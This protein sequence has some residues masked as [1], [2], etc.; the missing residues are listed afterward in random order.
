[1]V[2]PQRIH[3]TVVFTIMQANSAECSLSPDDFVKHMKLHLLSQPCLPVRCFYYFKTIIIA[4]NKWD[5]RHSERP[6][7]LLKIVSVWVAALQ[8]ASE[9]SHMQLL[10]TFCVWYLSCN[11]NLK[12]EHAS[13]CIC[14]WF[15]FES[16]LSFN[17]FHTDSNNQNLWVQHW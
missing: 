5:N 12:G 14:F 15:L 10:N 11:A 1:M 13:E 9:L 6:G 2:R 17:W 3:L 8:L 4:F 16:S 7:N